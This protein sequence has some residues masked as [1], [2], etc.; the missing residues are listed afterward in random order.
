MHRWFLAALG[1]SVLL[2]AITQAD[3]PPA[4]LKARFGPERPVEPRAADGDSPLPEGFPPA[5]APGVIEAKRYPAYRSAVAR[6][7]RATSLT[8]DLLFWPLFQHISKSEI[9][10]TAPVISSY[11]RAMV[12]KPGAQAEMAMEFLYRSPAQGEAGQGVGPVAVEDHP[13]ADCLCLGIQ[14]RMADGRMR[15]GIAA[16]RAWLDSHKGEWV[17]DKAREP[18]RLGYHGPMTPVPQRLWEVQLPVKPAGAKAKS[19]DR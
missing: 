7:P 12:E 2:P 9:A 3:D 16:L 11:P 6:N 8:G 1:A 10:M 13:E 15:D 14:G 4:D 19:E 5:T 17:E 18:R